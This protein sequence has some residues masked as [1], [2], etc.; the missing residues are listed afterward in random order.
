MVE[1]FFKEP[2][3][4]GVIFNRKDGKNTHWCKN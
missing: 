3:I 2:D 4:K 1:I